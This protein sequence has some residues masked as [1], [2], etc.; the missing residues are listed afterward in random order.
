MWFISFSMA[1]ISQSEDVF[2]QLC[3]CGYS[4][5]SCFYNPVCNRARIAL[6]VHVHECV[7]THVLSDLC[8][9]NCVLICTPVRRAGRPRRLFHVRFLR[10]SDDTSLPPLAY[11]GRGDED[12]RGGEEERRASGADAFLSGDKG[13]LR[14]PLFSSPPHSLQLSSAAH[15][16]GALHMKRASS[17]CRAN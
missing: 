1:T 4:M 16:S 8:Q 7:C 10:C 6:F 12:R 14:H 3:N 17:L 15:Q 2:C 11:Y 13:P 9:T 5:C